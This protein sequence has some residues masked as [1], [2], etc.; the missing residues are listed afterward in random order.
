MS[1]GDFWFPSS[2]PRI[3]G[4]SWAAGFPEFVESAVLLRVPEVTLLSPRVLEGRDGAEDFTLSSTDR[5]MVPPR[6]SEFE[7]WNP[8]CACRM[9][10]PELNV[11][12]VLFFGVSR[13][14]PEYLSSIMIYYYTTRARFPNVQTRNF[15]SFRAQF[16]FFSYC[17]RSIYYRVV[18]IVPAECFARVRLTRAPLLPRF[19]GITVVR[20]VS[21]CTMAR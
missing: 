12:I 6:V 3:G 8:S 18:S 21:Q 20:I 11:F 19:G 7:L 10:N 9:Q 16:L 1:P 5:P 2:N 13:G 15:Q 17:I 4:R 14:F